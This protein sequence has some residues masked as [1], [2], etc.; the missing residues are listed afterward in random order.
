MNE[1]KDRLKEIRNNLSGKNLVIIEGILLFQDQEICQYLDHKFFLE[2]SFEEAKKR[3]ESRT[4]MTDQG[5][6]WTFKT[7]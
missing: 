6:F 3:R 5:K 7:V 4:Y 1:L 2:I